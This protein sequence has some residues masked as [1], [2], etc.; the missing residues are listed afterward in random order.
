MDDKFNIKTPHT[1]QAAELAFHKL[2]ACKSHTDFKDAVKNLVK[3]LI[4]T[5][6]EMEMRQNALKIQADQLHHLL[7]GG[8]LTEQEVVESGLGKGVLIEQRHHEYMR[9]K[10]EKERDEARA[11]CAEMRE[12]LQEAFED[13]DATDLDR[14]RKQAEKALSSTCGRDLLATQRH[15]EAC[16]KL[17][18]VPNDETL[19][20]WLETALAKLER[21]RKALERI[22]NSLAGE[23]VRNVAREALKHL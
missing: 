7:S 8:T 13:R 21:Y 2:K 1:N 17:T 4:D 15:M 20:V 11:A 3:D 6:K 22:A 18:G 10:A 16:R 9:T 23:E 12:T 14:W 5:S 19:Y